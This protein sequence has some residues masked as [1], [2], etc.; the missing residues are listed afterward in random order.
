MAE[1]RNRDRRSMTDAE[2]WKRLDEHFHVANELAP[3]ERAAYVESVS[4]EDPGLG[5]ELRSLLASFDPTFLESAPPGSDA[6]WAPPERTRKPGERVR[7]FALI[8]LIGRGGMG[9]VY[10][11]TDERLN[12]EVALKFLP[13][14]YIQDPSFL[15]RFRSEA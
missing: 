13:A 7:D 11:A 15:E 12:R 10:R 9:E 3:A 1:A 2:S 4:T 5:D 6:G 8:E 14:E